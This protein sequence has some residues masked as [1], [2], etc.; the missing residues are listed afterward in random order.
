M[1]SSVSGSF[2]TSSDSDSS[3]GS[4]AVT[5]KGRP[6]T[7]SRDSGLRN[8]RVT[9][10]ILPVERELESVIDRLYKERWYPNFA[11][12]LPIPAR[13]QQNADARKNY[14]VFVL[15]V[16]VAITA[17]AAAITALVTVILVATADD[18]QERSTHSIK[19]GSVT[20]GFALLPLIALVN[21]C[22][23]QKMRLPRERQKRD[24][25]TELQQTLRE[26]GDNQV[27]L[28]P[29]LERL[30]TH[31]LLPRAEKKILVNELIPEQLLEATEGLNSPQARELLLS[32]LNDDN[33]KLL[34]FFQNPP[35]KDA[36]EF[37]TA[38]K[39][40]RDLLTGHPRLLDHLIS[41]VDREY[42]EDDMVKDEI[43]RVL[44]IESDDD[45]RAKFEREMKRL[46]SL[47]S[48]E[49][50]EVY[51]GRKRC[52]VNL[53]RLQQSRYFDGYFLAEDDDEDDPP[54]AILREVAIQQEGGSWVL[55][56]PKPREKGG[57]KLLRAVLLYLDSGLI[58]DKIDLSL[59]LQAAILYQVDSLAYACRTKILSAIRDGQV[60][61][62]DGDMI[63]I[64][65][66]ILSDS[67]LE[68]SCIIQMKSI[69][70]QHLGQLILEMKSHRIKKW[71]KFLH[72]NNR[73]LKQLWEEFDSPSLPK[74][75]TEQF[76][77][78]CFRYTPP[79]LL[80]SVRAHMKTE[81]ETTSYPVELLERYEDHQDITTLL[82]ATAYRKEVIRRETLRPLWERAKR[83]K[84]ESH[85]ICCQNHLREHP[86]NARHCWEIGKLPKRLAEA[87]D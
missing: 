63:E 46:H 32:Y 21:C 41:K 2:S 60:S 84:K 72:T 12:C 13:A 42:L 1:S 17:M 33:L 37:G 55:R 19:G 28:V 30:L 36:L 74:E 80:R 50:C 79:R 51:V 56:L 87:L 49:Q 3:S 4:F 54:T 48:E 70:H 20:A 71:L 8:G 86:E 66:A 39:Q 5:A 29:D 11:P 85:I 69:I 62:K 25:I 77:R 38:I 68:D 24:T 31:P 27:L 59:L 81:I 78:D 34:R 52:L 53:E 18:E 14:H 35:A 67:L 83:L 82:E 7:R 6:I 23:Q 9:S 43:E 22:Y 64:F 40:L 65:Q 16:P 73:V 15:G 75:L 44:E 76:V 45:D 57:A 58:D 10:I 61:F 47:P 26:K